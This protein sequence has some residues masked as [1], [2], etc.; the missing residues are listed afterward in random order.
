MTDEQLHIW[1]MHIDGQKEAIHALIKDRPPIERAVIFKLL[2]SLNTFIAEQDYTTPEL[3]MEIMA[4]V[5]A[6]GR[7]EIELERA[8]GGKPSLERLLASRLAMGM[9]GTGGDDATIK[10][11][12][13]H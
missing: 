10:K 3:L 11:I 1:N 9:R 5:V 2:M 6:A 12:L 7:A 8:T 13:T 4:W